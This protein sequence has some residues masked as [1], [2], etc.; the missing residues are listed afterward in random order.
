M[1]YWPVVYRIDWGYNQAMKLEYDTIYKTP[2]LKKKIKNRVFEEY[3]SGYTDGEG[4]FSVSFTRRDKFK[5][6]F[7]TK[8]SFTIS[9][10]FDRSEVLYLA[11]EYFDAGH[12]RRDKSDNTIK[13]EIRRLDDLIQ[14]VIP[15]F[16]KN[17]LISAKN[18]DFEI[19]KKIC[20]QM[21][22]GKHLTLDGFI[23]IVKLAYSMNGSIGRRRDIDQVIE[24]AKNNF[25]KKI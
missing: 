22:D 16:E 11:K 7:E 8:P 23:K 25:Q 1:H 18:K 24:I 15:H 5:V 4:C 3:L 20:F 2:T 6:G 21:N 19:F 13:Y 12:M 14:K 9:Q 17:P 10:N